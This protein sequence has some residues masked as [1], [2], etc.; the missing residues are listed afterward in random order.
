MTKGGGE[1]KVKGALWMR[2]RGTAFCQRYPGMLMLL[3]LLLL[4]MFMTIMIEM[5]NAPICGARMALWKLSN[6]LPLIEIEDADCPVGAGE[7]GEEGVELVDTGE[8]GDGSALRKGGCLHQPVLGR[9]PRI[10]REPQ[11][12]HD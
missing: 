6:D 12:V 1:E 11:C 3:L 9:L 4:L 7:E 2:N 8:G 5:S 10:G